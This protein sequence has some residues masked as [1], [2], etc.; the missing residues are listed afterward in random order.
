MPASS[1]KTQPPSICPLTTDVRL[2]QEVDEQTAAIQD[3]FPRGVSKP[4]LRALLAAGY[5][6]LEQLTKISERDLLKLHGMG[7]KAVRIL[8]AELKA[9]GLDFRTI[10]LNFTDT[11]P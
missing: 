6:R 2:R 8:R 10:E 5:Q 1:K 9:Q 4:A 11:Q 7:P 3:H